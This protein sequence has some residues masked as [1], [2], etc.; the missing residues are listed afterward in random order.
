MKETS[1]AKILIIGQAGTGK[2]SLTARY[3]DDT[4]YPNTCSTIGIDFRVKTIKIGNEYE[5][6]NLIKLQIWDTA[7][8]ERFNAIVSA[9][10]RNVTGVLVIFDLTSRESFEE[11]KNRW[12]PQLQKYV[13]E[14]PFVMVGNKNELLTNPFESDTLF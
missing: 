12:L 11:V 3:T 4:F 7:G 10:Y 1:I 13:P 9:F 6:P 5:T 14:T 2:S 8:Q